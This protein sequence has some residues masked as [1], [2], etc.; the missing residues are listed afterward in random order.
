[1]TG[2]LKNS[3]LMCLGMLI[4]SAVF[5]Q[6]QTETDS[7]ELSFDK[8]ISIVKTHHPLAKSA[9]LQV[10]KGEAKMLKAKGG[11]DPKIASNINQKNFDEKQYY[12]LFQAG[13]KIPTWYGLSVNAGYDLN[14]GDFLN[15][16]SETPDGGLI[17]GGLALTLGK[18]LLIDERRAALKDA[19]IYQE[20]TESKRLSMMNDLIF[21]A[22]KSYWDWFAAIEVQKA[23]QGTLSAA[24]ERFENVKEAIKQGDKPAF[25]SLEAR[26]QVQ[27]WQLLLQEAELE[28]L[29][30]RA[31]MSVHLWMDG[32]TPMELAS[33]TKPQLVDYMAPAPDS[34]I[35]A[36]NLK[37]T[38]IVDHPKIKIIGAQYRQLEVATRLQKEQ[39]KPT[40][41]LKYNPLTEAFGNNS[42]T[43]LSLNNYTWGLDFS[44]PIFL[45][46]E[47]GSLQFMKIQAQEMS[48]QLTYEKNLLTQKAGIAMN[49]IQITSTQFY[50]NNKNRADYKKLMEGERALFKGGES[51]LFMINSRETAFIKSQVNLIKI[52]IKNKKA[53]LEYQHALGQLN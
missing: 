10:Q 28:V 53:L 12:S 22:G 33:T 20:L 26:I 41:N 7:I 8:F 24:L 30:K 1:M 31:N 35:L 47:R 52:L 4:S 45:R 38:P 43:Q 50:L 25:D 39:L 19:E 15:P 48:Y 29:N 18:G 44:I 42:A 16:V 5:A 23:Y 32:E 40:L 9:D 37:E 13:L 36:L 46:K 27:N 6:D 21:N 14:S 34:S 17:Y 51:S 49:N 3:F 2:I 11:F